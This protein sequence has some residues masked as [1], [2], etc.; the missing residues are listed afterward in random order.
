MQIHTFSE[1]YKFSGKLK[2]R[3]FLIL[4]QEDFVWRDEKVFMWRDI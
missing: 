2:Q 3:N 4:E 1:I